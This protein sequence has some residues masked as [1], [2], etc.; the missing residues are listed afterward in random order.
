MSSLMYTQ[1]GMSFVNGVAG[2]I[3]ARSQANLQNRIVAFQNSMARLSAARQHNAVTVNE[4]RAQDDAV[5]TDVAIQERAIQDQS[6]QEVQAAAAGVAGGSVE[7]A[8]RDLRASAASARYAVKRQHAQQR[9]DFGAQHQTIAIQAVTGQNTQV[10]PT[11]SVGSML[12]GIGTN[13]LSIY[14]NSMP[15]GS[16]LLGPNGGSVS[17]TDVL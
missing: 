14:D 9:A 4:A 16:R 15:E 10:I 8:A 2:F 12:L 6:R 1:M 7:L 11:P 13:L 5:R 17:S 3:G